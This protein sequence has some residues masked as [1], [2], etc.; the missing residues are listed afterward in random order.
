MKQF[1]SPNV[2]Y[3]ENT[4]F[5]QR[6]KLVSSV[7]HPQRKRPYFK[8]VHVVVLVQGTYCGYCNDFKPIFQEVADQISPRV[9]FATIQIDSSAPSENIFQTNALTS[10][11]Q[12]PLQGVPLVVVFYNGKVVD[13]YK[14]ERTFQHFLQY[15]Q[16]F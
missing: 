16:Q 14:G 8:D 10:I 5:N 9:Q 2:V 13:T 11:I 15:A 3:L 6:H 4:D 12:Q 7:Q 1:T